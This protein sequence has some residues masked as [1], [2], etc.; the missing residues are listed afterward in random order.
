M[1]PPARGVHCRGAPYVG[2]SA[3]SAV[4]GWPVSGLVGW[5]GPGPV[6]RLLSFIDVSISWSRG[7]PATDDISQHPLQLGTANGMSLEAL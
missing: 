5:L 4:A 3:P 7:C 2:R 6:G 1:G